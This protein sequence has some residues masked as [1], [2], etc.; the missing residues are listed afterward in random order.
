[1]RPSRPW[2]RSLSWHRIM[3]AARLYRMATA[4]IGVPDYRN[5][6]EQKLQSAACSTLTACNIR[7]GITEGQALLIR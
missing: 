5:L 2:S 6:V 3:F 1:M 4:K 7:I